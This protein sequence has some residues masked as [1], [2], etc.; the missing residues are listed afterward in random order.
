MNLMRRDEGVSRS[1]TYLSVIN[2][3]TGVSTIN[4]QN[5]ET[6]GQDLSFHVSDL[7]G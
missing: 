2:G 5:R 6:L 7:P 3:R 1:K 4:K